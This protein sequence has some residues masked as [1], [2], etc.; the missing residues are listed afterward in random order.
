MNELILHYNMNNIAA[1]IISLH[2]NEPFN[3][4]DE[5]SLH[6]FFKNGFNG[7]HLRTS[8]VGPLE[9]TQCNL[10]KTLIAQGR[11]LYI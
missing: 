3:C 2:L 9:N 6:R 7:G 5:T 11:L 8:F 10:H 4:K 1:N